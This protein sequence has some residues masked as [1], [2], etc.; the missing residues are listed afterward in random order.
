MF[1]TTNQAPF[2]KHVSKKLFVSGSKR[3]T[4]FPAETSKQ[5]PGDGIQK[6]LPPKGTRKRK[7]KIEW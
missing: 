1:Q 7:T 4:P 2:G 5:L 6:E 3:C